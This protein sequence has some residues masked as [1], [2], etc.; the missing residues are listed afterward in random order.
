LETWLDSKACIQTN[1]DPRHNPTN[2]Q[3]WKRDQVRRGKTREE[4]KRKLQTW[5]L[6]F[7]VEGMNSCEQCKAEQ[8]GKQT[9]KNTE[10]FFLKNNWNSFLKTE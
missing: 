6:G 7:K 10:L 3:A 4:V 8:S 1:A 9:K 2:T 5:K